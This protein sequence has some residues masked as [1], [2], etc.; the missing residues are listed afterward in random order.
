MVH[1]IQDLGLLGN[2]SNSYETVCTTLDTG[3][4]GLGRLGSFDF[5]HLC[6]PILKG[7]TVTSSITLDQ[8]VLAGHLRR[9]KARRAVE[10][11]H[12]KLLFR[13]NSLRALNDVLSDY[14]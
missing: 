4:S 1:K 2:Q 3:I 11:T 13:S 6:P 7:I 5:S 14:G 9:E 10:A 8:A 12:R